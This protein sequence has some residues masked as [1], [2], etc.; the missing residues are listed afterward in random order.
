MMRYGRSIRNS[1]HEAGYVAFAKMMPSIA[2]TTFTNA[3]I[4]VWSAVHGDVTLSV[5]PPCIDRLFFGLNTCKSV[6]SQDRH[7]FPQTFLV[8]T[9][10]SSD[11][12]MTT[13]SVVS[14]DDKPFRLRSYQAEMVEESLHANIIVVMDTGSGKTHV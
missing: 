10:D 3:C 12:T 9:M 7:S 1:I 2:L 13:G 11:D 4:H 5:R 6:S 14:V 8:Q